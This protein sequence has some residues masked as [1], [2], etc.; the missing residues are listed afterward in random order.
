MVRG[1][2]G[3]VRERHS[4]AEVPGEEHSPS[5]PEVESGWRWV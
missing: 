1:V 5:L 3:G 4:K 2:A